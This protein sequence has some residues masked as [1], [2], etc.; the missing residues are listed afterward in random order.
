MHNSDVL[1]FLILG[2][3]VLAIALGTVFLAGYY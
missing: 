2:A 1:A 3:V